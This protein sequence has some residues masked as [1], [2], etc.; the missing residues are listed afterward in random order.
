MSLRVL[1]QVQALRSV[2]T[3]ISSL[4]AAL[5]LLVFLNRTHHLALFH[6]SSLRLELG[7]SLLLLVNATHL[8]LLQHA[9]PEALAEFADLE[10]L[11]IFVAINRHR[12]VDLG[13]K[14]LAVSLLP[15][16]QSILA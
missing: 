7:D 4:P 14:P 3:S 2:A 1:R 16:R 12:M 10:P 15:T 13:C 9:L 11:A 8:V 5:L 6:G